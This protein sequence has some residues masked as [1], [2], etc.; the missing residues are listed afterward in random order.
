MITKRFAKRGALAKRAKAGKPELESPTPEERSAET[1]INWFD[2]LHAMQLKKDLAAVLRHGEMSVEQVRMIIRTIIHN[3]ASFIGINGSPL[4][5]AMLSD[6]LKAEIIQHGPK[7][8]YSAAVSMLAKYLRQVQ[9]HIA[10]QANEKTVDGLIAFGHG[11]FEQ[12]RG[13]SSNPAYLLYR[14]YR[15]LRFKKDLVLRAPGGAEGRKLWAEAWRL[16]GRED[17]VQE[18][19]EKLKTLPEELKDFKTNTQKS[20]R[21]MFLDEIKSLKGKTE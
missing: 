18:Q 6:L 20:A 5:E 12:A 2:E 4:C 14:Y 8:N 1:P 7:W 16:A 9:R 3:V 15:D 21:R 11:V 17:C 19:L 13:T 10:E